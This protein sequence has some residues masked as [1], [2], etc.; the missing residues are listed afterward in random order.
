MRWS[1]EDNKLE[2]S[3][4]H[5]MHHFKIGKIRAGEERWLSV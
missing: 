5:K 1:L 2:I 4:V 3:L